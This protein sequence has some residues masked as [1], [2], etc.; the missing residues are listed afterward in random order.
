VRAGAAASPQWVF[1][2]VRLRGAAE[3]EEE[4]DEEEAPVPLSYIEFVANGDLTK[5]EVLKAQAIELIKPMLEYFARVFEIE[6]NSMILRM[7]AGRDLLD[8]LYAKDHI[9]STA[10]VDEVFELFRSL[11]RSGCAQ[12]GLQARAAPVQVAPRCYPQPRVAPGAV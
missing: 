9:P 11:N 7:Q 10:A 1:V 2:A 5:V 3:S 8:P 12:G 6:L 4:E